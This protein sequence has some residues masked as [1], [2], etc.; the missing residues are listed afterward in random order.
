[1]SLPDLAGSTP[2]GYI[3]SLGKRFTRKNKD[4][5][6]QA[7]QTPAGISQGAEKSPVASQELV[8]FCRSDI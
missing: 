2:D 7:T 5:L 4:F 8:N 3:G 1:M 6:R